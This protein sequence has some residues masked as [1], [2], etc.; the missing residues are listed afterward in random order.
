[1]VEGKNLS[2]FNKIS[3][4]SC[5]KILDIILCVTVT[6]NAMLIYARLSTVISVRVFPYVNILCGIISYEQTS[7]FVSHLKNSTPS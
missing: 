2:V 1:V 7:S 3:I 5:V 4:A 6:K